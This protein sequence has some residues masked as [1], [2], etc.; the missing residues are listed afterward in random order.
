MIPWGGIPWAL[1]GGILAISWASIFIRWCAAPAL[2]V[3]AWRLLLAALVWNLLRPGAWGKVRRSEV[4]W[5]AGAAGFLALHFGSWISSLTLTSVTSSVVLVTTSPLF[6]AL[7]GALWLREP[8]PRRFWPALLLASAG[9]VLVGVGETHGGSPGSHPAA[10]NA[11]A[12][13]GAVAMAGYLLIGRR[14][15]RLETGD[16]VAVVYGG[17]AGFLVLSCLATGA[18]LTGFRSQDWLW[19]ALLALIPQGIGHTLLNWA[20]RRAP[21]R[22]VSLAI[23][24]EPLGTSLLAVV[25]LNEV[26]GRLQVAGAGLILLGLALAGSQ[27]AEFPPP[28]AAGSPAS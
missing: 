24:G 9:A 11:L 26:P 23:L 16:Y 19:L 1:L 20:M 25:L 12:L 15:A 7:G 22:L 2:S 18:P 27:S 13:L 3:A 8:I 28:G 14:L 5:A 6:V 10:G 17:A 21:A 4:G